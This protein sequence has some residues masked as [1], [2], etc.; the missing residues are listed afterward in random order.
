MTPNEFGL[1]FKKLTTPFLLHRF[2]VC[3][4]NSMIEHL[5]RNLSPNEILVIQDFSENYSCLLPDEPQSLH[6]TTQQATV[7]PVVVLRSVDAKIVEDH[8]VFFSDDR[9]HD[10]AFVE[11]CAQTIITF[12]EQKGETFEN[13]IE[14]ND[15]CAQQFKSIK[16]FTQL[17][18]C[19][20][21]VTR[22]FF[23]T[24]HGKS[25]SDG[26]GGVVKSFVSRAV[27][28][29]K[30]FIRNAKELYD[31][32]CTYLTVSDNTGSV[33][34]NRKFFYVEVD[35]VEQ[36]RSS[37]K[38]DKYKY[39]PG[40]RKLHQVTT[41]AKD[42]S[43]FYIRNFICSCKNCLHLL[44]EPCQLPNTVFQK[45]S[46]PRDSK[47][48]W[49]SFKK[50]S[51][52]EESDDEEEEDEIDLI[53]LACPLKCDA[54]ESLD[55]GDIGVIQ[56]DDTVFSFYLLKISKIMYE[57]ES[58]VQDV[59]GHQY[60]PGSVLIHG[61]YLEEHSYD[62]NRKTQYYY[63]DSKEAV[64]SAYSIIGHCPAIE[65]EVKRKG[66]IVTGFMVDDFIAESL[67][68]LC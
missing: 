45:G 48:Q 43:G 46:G 44:S 53:N 64:V 10:V 68:E 66:K 17:A 8:F 51:K 11:H 14:L 27:S 52:D 37:V 31:F 38:N 12:Y 3:H 41:K 2:N 22:L 56:A 16:A 13:I 36:I 18:K 34:N 59:Y 23:E 9:T 25:K 20:Y 24:S 4:T 47:Y 49:Y 58:I 15:G 54:A 50:H 19:S 6:W 39:I 61:H 1:F 62:K 57:N 28:G 21:Q 33:M 63:V 60:H 42:R 29:E 35:D 65:T 5:E 55:I 30:V 26:L 7:Y 32:C 67:K 40:T